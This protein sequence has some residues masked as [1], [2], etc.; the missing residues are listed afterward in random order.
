M[1]FIFPIGHEDQIVQRMPYITIA[2][3]FFNI[4]IFLF[5][6]QSMKINQKICQEKMVN[7]VNFYNAHPSLDIDKI[8]KEHELG[9]IRE[10]LPH[11][12]KSIPMYDKDST[13]NDQTLFVELIKEYNQAA[14]SSPYYKYG[15]VPKDPKLFNYLS[16]IFMHGG[17]FHL[18]F[19]MIFLWLVGCNIEDRWGRPLYLGFYLISGITAS[20]AHI[21]FFPNSLIP[22]IGAS[23]A[24]AGC[25]GAFMVMMYKTKIRIFYLIWI[26]AIRSGTFEVSTLVALPFWLAQQLYYALSNNSVGGGVAF[27]AHIG[28]FIF[29]A[30][31]ASAIIKAKIEEKFIKPKID[32]KISYSQD[33]R[34]LDSMKNYD[35]ELYDEAIASLEEVLKTNPRNVDAILLLSRIYRKQEKIQDAVLILEKLESIYIRDLKNTDLALETYFEIFKKCLEIY[36]LKKLI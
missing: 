34:I 33:P 8:A 21:L 3:I 36:N 32:K 7:I 15:L 9:V 17:F 35:L 28:G 27:W 5:T 18:L 12:E 1:V 31:A 10:F 29:G 30:I 4:L 23:G 19:N 13:S 20:W 26:I 14:Q 24:I 2:I 22:L 6:S 16:S 11:S 25:M